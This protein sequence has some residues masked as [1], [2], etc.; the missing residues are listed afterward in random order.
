MNK[1]P[2]YCIS[3]LL[4][5]VL[6][7]CKEPSPTELFID[8]NISSDEAEIEIISSNPDVYVYSNGYDST[9]ITENILKN[10]NVVSV[11]GVKTTF[12]NNVIHHGYYTGLFEYYFSQNTIFTI[13]VGN[14]SA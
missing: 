2:K 11:A 10:T 5:V 1:F 9:G 7:S 6:V 4:I 8:E 3:I 13:E 14:R 12:K